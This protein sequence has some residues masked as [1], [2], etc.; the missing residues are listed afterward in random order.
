MSLKTLFCFKAERGK[1]RDR[2]N[3]KPRLKSKFNV[4]AISSK[5]IKDKIT[6]IKK[7]YKLQDF[8]C[9]TQLL[10]NRKL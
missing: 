1:E 4:S 9:L 5:P 10:L 8:L 2:G 7:F 3:F 6:R